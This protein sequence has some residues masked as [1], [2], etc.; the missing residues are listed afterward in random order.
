MRLHFTGVVMDVRCDQGIVRVYGR[1]ARADA[2]CEI[3]VLTMDV[4][5]G[6]FMERRTVYRLLNVGMVG[7][8]AIDTLGVECVTLYAW[9]LYL[10]VDGGACVVEHV[11]YE[12]DRSPPLTPWFCVRVPVVLRIVGGDVV[13]RWFD[14][15]GVRRVAPGG[16]GHMT[17]TCLGC[18]QTFACRA[19]FFL[20]LLPSHLAARIQ[21]TP[22]VSGI[23]ANL[24]M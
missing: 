5:G 7:D 4:W 15:W 20:H 21:D 6:N 18:K 23:V 16:G 12:M 1:E 8:F 24:V 10:P 3:L 2:S 9:D 17:Y 11:L 22:R 14:T 19:S 13:E